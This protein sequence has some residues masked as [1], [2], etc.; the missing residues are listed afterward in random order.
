MKQAVVIIHGMGEQIPME[1]LTGF[2][3]SVWTTDGALVDPGKPDPDTGKARGEIVRNASWSKPDRRN[4]SYELR[5]I[6][7]EAASNGRRVD[8]F[9]Y[10]WAHLITDTTWAQ[11]R[12]WIL[13]LMLRNP[14]RDVPRGVLPVWILLW[15]IALGGGV[16]FLFTLRPTLNGV[17]GSWPGAIAVALGTAILGWLMG[18][19]ASYFGDVARYVKAKPPNVARR[20]EIR[21]NGVQLLETLMGLRADGTFAPEGERAYDR[22]I[23][24]AHSL[25]TIVAYDI[26]THAF[27]RVNAIADRTADPFPQDKRIELEAM[28]RAG[29]ASPLQAG[30]ETEAWL[31]SYQALQA[32]ARRELNQTGNPWIVSDFVTLGSPL[33]HAEFL[34]VRDRAGLSEAKQQRVL[35][36]CPPT[37]EFDGKTKLHHFTYPGPLASRGHGDNPRAPRVPHHAALFAYTRWSN[38][39]SRH[40]GILWGDIISGPL[41]NAFSLEKGGKPALSGIRDIEVMPCVDDEGKRVAGDRRPFFSHTKYWTARKPPAK[42]PH[43]DRLRKALRLKE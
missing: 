40:W 38:L 1:T 41:R 33:T 8:F 23:V 4:R 37:L 2:V 28:I 31:D 42:N 3:D 16:A 29:L 19:F 13:E 6:T 26:L 25:G 11:V 9:E 20:Q 5:V 27:A 39:H 30:A 18:F 43:I 22:I 7:T 17:Q 21:E 12:A 14:R 15:L 24:V 32:D 36:S 34:M 35:P 10:Y